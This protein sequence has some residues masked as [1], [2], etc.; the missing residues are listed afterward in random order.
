MRFMRS[1][2]ARL[3]E[4]LDRR[5]VARAVRQH[6]GDRGVGT[7]EHAWTCERHLK[8]LLLAQF[9]GLNSLR[10]IEQRLGSQ[11]ASFYHLNLRA[12]CHPD[13]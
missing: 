13:Q 5:V 6:R 7:G 11:A 4:P 1:A 3:L 12:P 8:A 10:E 2:F 9:A